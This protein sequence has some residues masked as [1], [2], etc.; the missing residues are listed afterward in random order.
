MSLWQTL[1]PRQRGPRT[2]MRGAAA[3]VAGILALT[4]ALATSAGA[5]PHA[6]AAATVAT[7]APVGRWQFDEGAGTVANDSAGSHNATIV[8]GAGWA[9][10]IQGSSSM[11]TNG[12]NAYADTGATVLDTTSSFTVNTWVKLNSISRFQTA[13]S[14]DGSQVSSFF[15]GLRDDT[16]RFAFVRLPGDAGIGAPAFP[17]GSSDPVAGQWYQLTG[18]YD[19]SA[20]TLSLYVNGQLQQTTE[21]PTAWQASGH[22]VI[23]RGKFGGGP[24]DWVNGAVDDTRVYQAALLPAAIEQLA[25]NGSWRLDEGTG[26][27]AADDSLSHNDAT[28][29]S[30]A[31]WTSGIVGDHALAFDGSIGAATTD[32]P[33]VD[34]TQGFS[35]AAW[36]KLNTLTGAQTALSVDGSSISGFFLTKRFDGKWAFTRR[37]A[38]STSA[39]EVAAGSASAATSGQWTHL[40][41][42]YD[43]AGKTITLYVNGIKQS[44]TA[45]T[46]PWQAN[47][48]FAIGRAKWNGAPADFWNGAIDEVHTY[49]FVLDAAA[50]S[51]LSTSG[52][53][54]FDEGSGTVA[55]DASRSGL[56]GTLSSRATWGQ[57]AS[58][59]AVVLDGTADVVMGAAPGLNLTA[60]GTLTAWFDTKSSA[61]QTILAKG[62][63]AGGYAVS[64]AA[65]QVTATLGGSSS[66]LT[67][68]S[69]TSSYA[70]GIWHPVAVTLDSSALKATL[71]LDGEAVASKPLGTTPPTVS[72]DQPF[73][74]GAASDDSAGF[75]GSIDEVSVSQFTL[76]STDIARLAGYNAL[77]I[78]ATDVRTATRLTAYGEILEDIS[79]S[80]D[81]GLYAELVRNRTFKEKFQGSGPGSTDPVPYWSLGN[82]GGAQ[83]TFATDTTTPLNT[84]IERSLK[85]S[86]TDLAKGSAA[87]VANVGYYG[88]KV[89]PKTTYT[90]S[91]WTKGSQGFTGTLQV[92]LQKADGT[93]LA[94]TALGATPSNWTKRT[95]TLQTPKG[96]VD[97]TDNKVVV[98][99]LGCTRSGCATTAGDVWL[100]NVSVFPPTFSNRSN[101]LRTDIMNKFANMDLGLFRVPGGNYLEGNTLDTRFDWKKTIGPIE[102]RPGH[103]NT[104]WGYWSTDGMG[105]LE[106][107]QMAEDVHAQPL[108]AVFA[109]YTLNGQHVSEADY[110]PYIEDALDEIEYAIGDTTTT[111]GA[112]RAAD[113]HPAK[114]D[115]HYVEIGNEDGFDRS[116]SYEWR[117]SRMYDA[118]KAKY[119]SLQI[120]AS[121]AVSSRTPDVVDEHFYQPASSF[122]DNSTRY[123]TYS[124]SGPQILVGEY[125][126]LEGS[127]T[128]SLNA[129]VGEAAFLTGAERNSD[130][131]VGTMYAPIIVNENASNW[132]TNMLGINAVGSYG[133]PSYWV[134][135]MFSTNRGANVVG[136]QLSAGSGLRQVVTATKTK[137]GTT[138]YVKIV[139]F[140]SQ[141]QSAKITLDGVTSLDPT[142]TLT[143]LTSPDANARNTLTSPQ[144]VVPTTSTVKMAGLSN[145]VSVPGKS[146]IVLKVVG[147]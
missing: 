28:L 118:I 109:G 15:L 12:S 22:L 124:R 3:A 89:S 46:T 137:K 138:F 113:G 30:G 133:S 71:W 27:T 93:V 127:P 43:A 76:S 125:G 140:S 2:S 1:N 18:V 11:T 49:P 38:D 37:S 32:K 9:A 107:L 40:V 60:N 8:G 115:L 61:T 99:L 106:Y 63:A 146:V 110:Q 58:N 97:A 82:A 79:H 48:A 6:V 87:W 23:G 39:T 102:T 52:R 131:V 31:S 103:Q 88:I 136:S 143:M 16:K 34:T 41:G 50:V 70:D 122:N 108:L 139:N 78:H 36:V 35:V 64:I 126:A 24:V 47:G 134:Q 83:S 56:D 142:G 72:S 10:G 123:D 98:S 45:F 77:A 80:V 95:F 104:A 19:S 65:G 81:G 20:N 29:T 114:F 145:R 67:L 73:V 85:V 91:L 55:H 69:P 26:T 130:I 51:E 119:P 68:T 141:Q 33:V 96:V 62:A 4:A 57:G 14:V 116:G 74:V 128:G 86:I 13:V 59:T 5:V 101:G 25:T 94:S 54:H 66:A 129:A 75:V 132:Y 121:T 21:A 7:T 135:Q 112:K 42:V 44:T 90:G 92:S 53:W 144:A 111:W 105:I 117:F 84:A 17:S 100:S 120:V 147:H